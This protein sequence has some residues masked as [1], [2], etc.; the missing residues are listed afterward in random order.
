MEDCSKM[1]DAALLHSLK[2]LARDERRNLP[3][4]LM[5]LAEVRRRDIAIKCGYNSLYDY[6][7]REL[8]WSESESARRI[9]AAK[10]AR[11]FPVLYPLLWCGRL[12]LSTVSIL[13]PHLRADN[14]RALIKKAL[15]K[16]LREVEALVADFSPRRETHE[17]IRPLGTAAAMP[18]ISARANATAP[19]FGE[20]TTAP[21]PAATHAT[22]A[23]PAPTR[24]QFTFTG[25][26]ALAR[27][28]ERSRQ[29]LRN[30]HPWC[31]LE[32]VFREAVASL[33]ERLDPDRRPLPRTRQ[34]RAGAAPSR[35]IPERVKAAVWRRD[36]GACVFES[37]DGRRCGSRV[38]LEYDH[39]RP[40]ARGGASDDAANVRLLCR[41]H[42]LLQARRAFGGAVPPR[43]PGGERVF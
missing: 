39:V 14:H 1:P 23:A 17:R 22:A 5:R 42:N 33:L 3:R 11:D 10:A 27:D 37:R 19:L 34:P 41:A 28:V 24:V 36:G 18:E 43:A 26:E 29:L 12:T 7:R 15:G 21:L 40:W 35:R 30:K 38:F 20:A 2:I 8:R 6:C 32:D 9:Q 16:S 13:A 31:R 4:I 25:D